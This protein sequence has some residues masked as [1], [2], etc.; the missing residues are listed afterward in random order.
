M[1]ASITIMVFWDVML[2]SLVERLWHFEGMFIPIYQT[3]QCH[4]PEDCNLSVYLQL[5]CYL[6]LYRHISATQAIISVHQ[7]KHVHSQVNQLFQKRDQEGLELKK[8]VQYY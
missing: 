4:I 1:A 2:C 3:E 5:S 6:F 7:Y 8:T